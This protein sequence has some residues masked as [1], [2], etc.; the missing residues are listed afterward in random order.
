MAELKNSLV[1]V[2]V[3]A[4]GIGERF[5]PLS[6]IMRPKQLLAITG[7]ETMLRNTVSR[8]RDIASPENI[9][10]VTTGAQSDLIRE[11]VKELPY[12]NVIPEPCGR[13]TAPCVALGAAL[14][15]KK[16]PESVMVVVS[17]DHFIPDVQAYVET[18][19]DAVALARQEKALVTI[20]VVPRYAE[21][22]YGYIKGETKIDYP[23]AAKA[24]R[25]SHFLEK[26]PLKV[27]EKLYKT[28]GY[29][30]NAGMFVFQTKD[31]LKAFEE[32][33]PESWKDLEKIIAK[34]GTAGEREAIENYYRNVPKISIDNAVMEKA[35]NVAVCAASFR[36]N[37]VGSWTSASQHWPKD[38]KANR[39]KG[40]VKLL[41]TSDCI[42]G[43]Y[44]EGLVGVIG[45]N[46]VV[47]IRTADA[48]L[49]CARDKV[50]DVKK[51]LGDLDEKYR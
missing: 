4:G 37:D 44:A 35:S 24:W 5:W 8:H 36:W 49:V 28:P 13:N 1:A 48:T 11:E 34:A 42:V 14:L 25:V 30:W 45:L 3:M 7:E 2:C 20:G 15:Y 33:M 16:D 47:I 12:G 21:T 46:D 50:Q 26:P 31:I 41:E 27:A 38:E 10:I 17:A 19:R 29:F 40:E 9:Y 43:N 39:L 6:R 32:F 51:I 18:I 22:G 23:G